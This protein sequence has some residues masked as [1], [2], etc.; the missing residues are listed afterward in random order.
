[1]GGPVSG[2]GKGVGRTRG[3][4]RAPRPEGGGAPAGKAPAAARDHASRLLSSPEVIRKIRRHDPTWQ[5]PRLDIP[6]EDPD[7]DQVARDYLRAIVDGM[8]KSPAGRDTA[9]AFAEGVLAALTRTRQLQPHRATELMAEIW[10]AY[11]A[12]SHR[13]RWGAIS[14]PGWFIRSHIGRIGRSS[15]D[16]TPATRRFLATRLS[17]HK[18]WLFLDQ[19]SPSLPSFLRCGQRQADRTAA[20]TGR[21]RTWLAFEAGA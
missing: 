6:I 16:W 1:M 3:L 13:R 17:R 15:G 10:R 8:K 21:A 19:P 12:R 20:S 4:R 5:P 14:V 2:C 18:A 7:P 11:E 9:V